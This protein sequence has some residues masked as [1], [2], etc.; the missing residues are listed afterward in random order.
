MKCDR[1][2]KLQVQVIQQPLQNQTYPLQMYNTASGQ[3]LMPGNIA[4]HSGINPQQIQ[5][6]LFFWPLFNKF[7]LRS[8][9]GNRKTISK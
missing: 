9:I 5:V 7:K 2:F 4:L 6:M 3:L 1:M 8:C